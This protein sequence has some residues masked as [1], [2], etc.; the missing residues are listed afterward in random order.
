MQGTSC[1]SHDQGAS[2]VNEGHSHAYSY[3]F[4][5]EKGGGGGGGDPVPIANVLRARIQLWKNSR[6]F[7]PFLLQQLLLC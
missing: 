5:Q 6:C 7:E 1:Y 3:R 2:L 4:I